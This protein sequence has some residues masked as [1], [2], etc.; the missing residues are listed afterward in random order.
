V[1]SQVSNSINDCVNPCCCL[2]ARSRS[3]CAWLVSCVSLWASSPQCATTLAEC[4]ASLPRGEQ[5]RGHPGRPR[6]S[7]RDLCPRAAT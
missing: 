5:R 6:V 7:A 2:V 3:A 4:V 1:S